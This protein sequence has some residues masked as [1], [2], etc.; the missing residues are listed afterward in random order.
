MDIAAVKAPGREGIIDKAAGEVRR[1]RP[2][3]VLRTEDRGYVRVYASRKTVK[4]VLAPDFLAMDPQGNLVRK[5]DVEVHFTADSVTVHPHR[6]QRGAPVL[7]GKT[8]EM[9][10]MVLKTKV[11]RAGES[12]TLSRR[13]G[14]VEAQV[15]RG[16]SGGAERYRIDPRTGEWSLRWHEHPMRE[17]HRAPLVEVG[18]DGARREIEEEVFEEIGPQGSPARPDGPGR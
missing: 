4:A 2:E 13:E 17:P 1:K 16:L 6:F 11:P 10:A 15:S 5:E 3:F 8:N 9:V 18:A 7:D 12:L 14:A